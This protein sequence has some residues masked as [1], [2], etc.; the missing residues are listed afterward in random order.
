MTPT[1]HLELF[2]GKNFEGWAFISRSTNAPADTWS[3]TNG[4]IH[5]SGKS[6]GYLRTEK[7]FRDYKLTVEWRFVKMAPKVD[8]TGVLVHMQLPDKVWPPCVQVQGKHDRQGDLFLMAGAESR[9]HRGL[10]ANTAIPMRGDSNEKPVGEWNICEAVC[11]TNSVKAC[12]NGRLLNET[13]ECTVSSGFIGI[14]SEG[15][16]FE[17]R[18]MFVE[19]VK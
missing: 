18:K 5:C 13:T 1:N 19:P 16:E 8:N 11:A 17:I 15:A 12:I 4:V 6:V 2:N 3:V 7:G 14:Q 10:D 9:E